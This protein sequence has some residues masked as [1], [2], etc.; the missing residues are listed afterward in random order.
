[1]PTGPYLAIGISNSRQKARPYSRFTYLTCS[2]GVCTVRCYGAKPASFMAISPT[3]LLPVAEIDG[4]VILQSYPHSCDASLSALCL[5]SPLFSPCSALLESLMAACGTLV[6]IIRESNDIAGALEGM[7]PESKRMLPPP[8]A[9]E[10]AAVGPL[11]RLERELFGGKPFLD[12]NIKRNDSNIKRKMG[13]H[14][15]F[16]EG[17]W[18][19]CRKCLRTQLCVHTVSLRCC[20]G[21][22][23]RV[24]ALADDAA[25]HGRA[26]AWSLH[27][28]DRSGG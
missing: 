12:S 17:G 2:W 21:V 9:P 7:F 13:A 23:C 15:T 6:Q 19:S 5:S 26:S 24:A 18:A 25:A 11:L 22:L 28:H 10:A 8:E 1:M 16:E 20:L 3:G 4:Q 27:G 14:V